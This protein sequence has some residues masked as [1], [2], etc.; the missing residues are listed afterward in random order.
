MNYIIDNYG[1][2][3]ALLTNGF[4]LIIGIWVRI[5]INQNFWFVIIGNGIL[6]IGLNVMNT[7]CPKVAF[8]WFKPNNSPIVTSILMMAFALG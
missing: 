3:T 2:K 6:G 7:G 5:F 8:N 1:M 4:F